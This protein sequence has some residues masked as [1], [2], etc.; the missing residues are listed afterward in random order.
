MSLTSK[1][2]PTEIATLRIELID[3]DPLIWR[4]LEVPTSI[5]LKALHDIVQ[6]SM[7]WEDYHFWQFVVDGQTYGLPIKDDWEPPRKIASRVRLRDVLSSAKSKTKITYTYDFGDDWEHRLI[8]SKVR[9]GLPNIVYPRFIAGERNAPPE[10]CGGI[11]GF[12]DKLDIRT[13]PNDPDHAHITE[14]FG[15][16]DPDKLDEMPIRFALA[17]IAARA[18]GVATH[19]TKSAKT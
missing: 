10:D 8:V 18:K 7:N 1:A 17:R 11:Y 16:Y 14:W 4:E 5:K 6:A 15:D 13:D 12:Y 9:P 3:S 2:D 19:T